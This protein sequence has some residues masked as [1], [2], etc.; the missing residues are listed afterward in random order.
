MT[1]KIIREWNNK[2][3]KNS[4]INPNSIKTKKNGNKKIGNKKIRNKKIG[5][6]KIQNTFIHEEIPNKGITIERLNKKSLN[7][8]NNNGKPPLIIRLKIPDSSFFFTKEDY[9]NKI[10]EATDSYPLYKPKDWNDNTN[11]KETHNC[12]AYSLGVINEATTDKVQPGYF[13]NFPRLRDSDY[14]CEEFSKRLKKDNPTMYREV[15]NKKCKKGYHKAVL[16]IAD[17][18]DKD[19]HFYR[20]DRNGLW[21]HK[22]GRTAVRNRDAIGKI[23]VNPLISDRNFKNGYNYSKPCFFFCANK[24]FARAKSTTN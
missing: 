2:N 8:K 22:P 3:N 4:I 10:S 24:K 12:Y 1:F 19:Y 20:Q 18:P 5:N 21:S 9:I 7:N 11:V 17:E 14:S 16:A 13:A 6:K 23:I 15:F